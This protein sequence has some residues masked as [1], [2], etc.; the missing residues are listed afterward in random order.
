MEIKVRAAGADDAVTAARMLHDFNTEF[1]SPTPSVG[2]LT[3]R[4]ARL[5]VRDDVR[6]LLA[7]EARGEVQRDE[8]GFAF[9][10]VRPSAYCDAGVAMLEELYVRP[11][12]RGRGT[13][14][15]LM[16][17]LLAWVHGRDVHEVQIG[18]DSVDV[19]ARRFYER[20]GFTNLEMAGPGPE[21]ATSR[22][23]MY[24]RED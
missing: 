21:A 9:L 15:A 19:D 8:I 1:A 2:E 20:H 16:T 6:V 22:M 23:L 24:V 17:A 18:V 7:E 12:V 5:L 11:E 3:M 10:T 4:F 13:G 14:T